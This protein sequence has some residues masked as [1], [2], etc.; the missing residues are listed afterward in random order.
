M[1]APATL[2]FALVRHSLWP[3]TTYPPGLL[4]RT[5]P[6][7]ASALAPGWFRRARYGGPTGALS[8]LTT[9]TVESTAFANCCTSSST[10]SPRC[11]ARRLVS[12]G[13]PSLLRDL[14]GRRG[15][16]RARASA[17]GNELGSGTDGNDLPAADPA[18]RPRAGRGY[19]R[20]LRN[21]LIA[22]HAASSAMPT[23][24]L[25]FGVSRSSR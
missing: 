7:P 5:L 22:A 3:A 20:W 4:Q 14:R 24:A 19:H 8:A 16:V 25:A 6:R 21:A 10:R 17:S 18:K 1:A 13:A 23:R 9:R 15:R 2:P 11:G 12:L